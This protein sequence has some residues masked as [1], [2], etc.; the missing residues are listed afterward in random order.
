MESLISLKDLGKNF[1]DIK[2]FEKINLDIY[3]QE[4]VSFF[5]P[6]GCGKSS[7]MNIIAGID[8]NFQGEIK[9]SGSIGYIFQDFR[10]SL[11]PW[12]SVLENI[13]FPL[14]I[15]GVARKVAY[16]KVKDLVSETKIKLDLSAYPFM[17]SGGEAQMVGVLRAL[18]IEPDV[19][20]FDEPFSAL[21]YINHLDMIMKIRR[22][23]E[24]KRF[25]V[26]FVSHDLDEAILLGDRIV[27]FSSRPSRVI[28]ELRCDLGEKRKIKDMTSE[29]F[30]KLKKKALKVIF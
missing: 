28:K 17:L 6:N 12:E 27:F 30:L 3:K 21:D 19:L 18:I 22:L 11:L 16:K 10:Q 29:K 2:I 7:L 25:T 24:K 23:Y 20:I 5:G 13:A 4:F 26:L 14:I 9:F 1:G 8:K 15:K